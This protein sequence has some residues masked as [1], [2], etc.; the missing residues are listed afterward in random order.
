[1][2]FKSRRGRLQIASSRAGHPYSAYLFR[3]CAREALFNRDCLY[4]LAELLRPATDR[5]RGISRA[6]ENQRAG[7]GHL[8]A[9]VNIASKEELT[10]DSP[11]RER[12]R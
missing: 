10:D 9:V 7:L 5:P 1:M 2:L 6:Q 3:S 4:L 8:A 12:Y 11:C